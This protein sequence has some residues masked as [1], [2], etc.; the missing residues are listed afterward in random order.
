M[1]RHLIAVLTMLLLCQTGMAQN[2]SV[3]SADKDSDGKVTVSEFTNYAK[4]KLPDLD[5]D[6][7]DSFVKNVDADSDG[8]VTEKEFGNR[9]QALRKV[10]QESEQAKA[11]DEMSEDEAKPHV[12]GD[13]ASDFE[14][15][16]IGKK[17]KLSD[18]VS[19]SGK[20]TVVVF[21]RA[22]W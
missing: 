19:K 18:V 12:V 6:E 11:G 1:S 16:S 9:M 2:P 7:L 15:Q 8:E 22:N 4:T 21:S 13:K 5:D 20:P 10:M 14:L 3:K 17:I